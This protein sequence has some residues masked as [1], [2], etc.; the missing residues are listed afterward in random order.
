MRMH[1]LVTKSGAPWLLLGLAAA[2]GW[3]AAVA[4]S[5][6]AVRELLAFAAP[7]ALL[8]LAGSW[9]FHAS[10]PARFDWRRASHAVL[11]GALGFPPVVAT[12]TAL[13]GTTSYF[14]VVT[15]FVALAWIALLVGFLA[16]LLSSAL[17]P[18]E[19]TGRR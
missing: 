15:L 3:I 10:V 2:V 11:A 16:G 8:A 4:P 13:A 6:I 7:G 9:A 14:A 5:G 12:V 1:R 19:Q 17:R 18:A